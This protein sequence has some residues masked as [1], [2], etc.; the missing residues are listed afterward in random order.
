MS[1]SCFGKSSQILKELLDECC[2]EYAKLLQGK[3]CIYEPHQDGSWA[4]SAVSKVRRI[5]TVIIEE[6]RKEMLL[7]DIREFL[8][9]AS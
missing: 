3:T 6:K 4:R 9:P 7:G 2:T 8:N 5:S 1:I